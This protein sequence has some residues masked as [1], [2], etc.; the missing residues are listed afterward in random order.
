MKFPGL[1]LEYWSDSTLRKI[2]STLGPV[3]RVD[4]ATSKHERMM[5]ARVQIEMNVYDEYPYEIYF[6]NEL[7]EL[8]CQKIGRTSEKGN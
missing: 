7:E 4:N 2:A 1:E 3:V 5:Y 6:I 8:V